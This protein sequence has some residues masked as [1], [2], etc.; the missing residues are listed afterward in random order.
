MRAT[1]FTAAAS[2]CILLM[3]SA[4]ACPRAS[5]DAAVEN[6]TAAMTRDGAAAATARIDVIQCRSSCGLATLALVGGTY[7]LYAATT[8]ATEEVEL[9]VADKGTGAFL[10][11][12]RLRSTSPVVHGTL[13]IPGA[14]ILT[15][16]VRRPSASVRNR[17][18]AH[19]VAIGIVGPRRIQ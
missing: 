16:K 12:F 18:R 3:L 9:D 8:A 1:N 2:A 10:G 13:L 5:G 15:V 7:A 11:R 14:S 19:D 17:N 6:L 4:T